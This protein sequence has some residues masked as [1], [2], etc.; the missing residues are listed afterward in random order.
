MGGHALLQGI[1]PTQGSNPRLSGLLNGQAGSSPLAP[2]GK[3][4][5]SPAREARESQRWRSA[6]P[7]SPEAGRERNPAVPVHSVRPGVCHAGHQ[8]RLLPG[9]PGAGAVAAGAQGHQEAGGARHASGV[10]PAQ[11]R[12]AHAHPALPTVEAG[13]GSGPWSLSSDRR[14]RGG[15]R[16]LAE[17]L[18]VV[19]RGRG[20]VSES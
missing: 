7:L 4:L 2:A 17:G 3:V 16:T 18:A 10:Q 9:G 12:L 11:V 6:A 15:A 5:S 8:R 19:T 13:G 20:P 1:F 14:T